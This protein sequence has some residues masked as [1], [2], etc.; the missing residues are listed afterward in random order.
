[1]EGRHNGRYTIL[2]YIQRTNE[3]NGGFEPPT[4]RLTVYCSTA[5]LIPQ[6]KKPPN[7]WLEGLYNSNVIYIYP[8]ITSPNNARL[9]SQI[10]LVS[11]EIVCVKDV[12]ITNIYL[13]F[14]IK[15]I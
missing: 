12:F 11:I 14:K 15:V 7:F 8:N 3:G 1:M 13:I 2:A 5:E 6:N 10:K 4:N 9:P